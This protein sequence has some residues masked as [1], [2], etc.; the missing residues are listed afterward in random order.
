MSLLP[1]TIIIT[2]YDPGNNSRFPLLYQTIKGLQQY[3]DYPNLRWTITDDGSSNHQEMVAGVNSLLEGQDL[4]IFNTER[5]GVGYAKNNALK[6]AFTISPI[7]LLLEDDW[8][9]V[10]KLPLVKYVQHLLDHPDTGMIRFGFIG[11]TTLTATLVGYSPFDTYWQLT[12]GSDV[13]VYSG[14]VSIR[15]EGFYRAVGF[16]DE[17]KTPGDEELEMCKTYNGTPN[18]P[19]ILWDAS[20]GVTLNSGPFHNIGMGNSLNS[21]APGA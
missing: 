15:S 12:Q 11:G 18:A 9:L 5:R 17:G 6:E 1:V 7:V 10:Q 4:R 14:Q 2:T 19:K 13:Y 8:L 21:V 3:L 20:F 16:H